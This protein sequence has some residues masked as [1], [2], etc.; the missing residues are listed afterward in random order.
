MRV[1]YF[2]TY[3]RETHPR[4]GILLDGLRQLGDEVTE[5]NAPLGFSTAARVVVAVANA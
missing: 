5:L 3:D 2:G 4:V 1:L